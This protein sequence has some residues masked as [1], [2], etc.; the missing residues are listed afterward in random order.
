L[1]PRSKPLRKGQSSA[2]VLVAVALL[3]VI[4]GAGVVIYQKAS[5]LLSWGGGLPGAIARVTHKAPAPAP[6]PAPA[7]TSPATLNPAPPKPRAEEKKDEGP[8]WS[9]SRLVVVRASN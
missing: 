8:S 6:P 1:A 4:T 9:H 2:S 7:K 3:A 5:A